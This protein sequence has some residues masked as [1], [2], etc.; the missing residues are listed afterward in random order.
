MPSIVNLAFAEPDQFQEYVRGANL[1]VVVT[2]CGDYRAELQRVQLDR[3]GLQRGRQSL[4]NV[5]RV[6]T[7]ADRSL[8]LFHS[9]ADEAPS[10]AGNIEIHPSDIILSPEQSQDYYRLTRD[11]GWASLSSAPNDLAI[12]AQILGGTDLLQAYRSRIRRPPRQL[13]ARLRTLH[14]AIGDL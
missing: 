8:I 13:M 7:P 5:G 11:T 3:L 14:K 9:G 2:A 10:V 12:A 6:T 4:P 1:E